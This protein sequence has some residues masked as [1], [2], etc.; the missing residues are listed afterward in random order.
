MQV[1][2]NFSI[3]K[4]VLCS[5]KDR[6]HHKS[7][8]IFVIAKILSIYASLRFLHLVKQN[9]NIIQ[10]GKNAGY[11]HFFPF[12][13]NSSEGLSSANPSYMKLEGCPGTA[14]Q[15]CMTLTLTLGQPEPMFQMAHSLMKNNCANLYRTRFKIE[16]VKVWTKI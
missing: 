2:S 5:I 11:Q 7:F 10:S 8:I 1:T 9:G 3:T 4:N 16:G 15:V 14:C 13:E 12:P 6:N